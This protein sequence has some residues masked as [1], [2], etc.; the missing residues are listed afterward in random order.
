[1]LGNSSSSF[2]DDRMEFGRRVCV[3][4]MLPFTA[5]NTFAIKMINDDSKEHNT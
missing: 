4:F 5:M 1:M 3:L 2:M